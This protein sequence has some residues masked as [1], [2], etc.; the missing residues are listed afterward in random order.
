MIELVTHDVWGCS[1]DIA[2]SYF[3]RPSKVWSMLHHGLVGP[4]SEKN[5]RNLTLTL[6]RNL[7][8]PSIVFQ[9]KTIFTALSFLRLINCLPYI[10][11]KNGFKL[12]LLKF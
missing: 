10:W 6:T 8:L 5:K 9:N 3:F 1:S 12:D 7:L 11:K 4:N 2:Y